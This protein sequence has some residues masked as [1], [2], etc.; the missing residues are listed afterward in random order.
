MKLTIVTP[1]LN[2]GAYIGRTIDS[3]I[4]QRGDFQIQY[5]VRDGG[6]TDGT[7]EILKAA[8][9]RLASR[10]DL[11]NRGVEFSW[12]SQID[13]GQSAAINAGLRL[14]TGDILAYLNSDDVYC[15]G[16]FAAVVEAFQQRREADFVYG[17]GQ[18]IDEQDNLQWIWLARPYDFRMLTRH[19]EAW[20]SASNYISQA[21]TFWRRSVID[22]IGLFDEAFHNAMDLEYWIRAGAKGLRLDHISVELSKFRLIQGTKSLSS[23]TVFWPDTVEIHRRYA[24]DSLLTTCGYYLYNLVLAHEWDLAAA[25]AEY[26]DRLTTTH[27][28]PEAERPAYERTKALGLRL[29]KVICAI[30]ALRRGDSPAASALYREAMRGGGLGGHPAVWRYRLR[31]AVGAKARVWL[32]SAAQRWV[33]SYKRRK[34]DYRYS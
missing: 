9:Q 25:H 32:E 29:G 3:V 33:A 16:A 26:L 30:D 27:R 24:P 13:G 1:S 17:D 18:V 23:P 7:V 20:N 11:G 19:H 15:P 31:R 12:V 2:Q 10:P 8:E 21:S 4:G 22:R 5:L 34:I 28:I 6:S 14:A